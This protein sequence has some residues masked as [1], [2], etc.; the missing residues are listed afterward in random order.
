[1]E[2]EK[3]FRVEIDYDD[4]MSS[5]NLVNDLDNILKEYRIRLEIEDE[6]HDGFDVCIVT[7]NKNDYE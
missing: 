3:K 5:I 6:E 2:L 1:M 7:I 4:M